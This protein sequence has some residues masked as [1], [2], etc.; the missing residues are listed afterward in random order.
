QGHEA[1][2]EAAGGGGD[3]EH[4]RRADVGGEVLL[5]A[6]GLGTGGDPARAQG[7][8]DLVDLHLADGRPGEGQEGVALDER[9]GH[10]WISGTRASA[11]GR[12]VMSR[13]LSCPR[14]TGPGT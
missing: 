1:D 3:G 10:L 13:S 14:R 5:E 4:L 12:L 7:V 8:D 11:C 9:L 6:L 2:V